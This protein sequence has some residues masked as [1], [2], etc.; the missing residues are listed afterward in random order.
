MMCLVLH[1]CYEQ[2]F[3]EFNARSLFNDW[4]ILKGLHK[5][6]I[7]MAVIA[8]SV[9]VQF[10]LVTFGGSFAG[11]AALTAEQWVTTI[12]IGALAIP[13]GTLTRF[14]PITEKPCDFQSISPIVAHLAEG[15]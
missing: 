6:A 7:F 1:V 3:N 2:I 5:N 8:T 11:T 15:V 14:I 12:G 9:F 10:I 4:H 13:V